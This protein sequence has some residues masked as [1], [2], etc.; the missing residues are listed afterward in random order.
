MKTDLASDN[1]MVVE[2]AAKLARERFAER[3]AGY[4]RAAA[5]PAED[6]EDLFAAGLH[7]PT[8]PSEHGG[9]GLGPLGGDTF[10]LWMITKELAKADLSLAR[11]WEGHANSLL[12]IDALGTERQKA[13]WWPPSR[14]SGAS[15]PR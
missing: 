3:A 2:R 7:A 11:C 13:E 10:A 9:L 6:F 14:V 15:A 1:G 8:V 5:F 12:L 4:D